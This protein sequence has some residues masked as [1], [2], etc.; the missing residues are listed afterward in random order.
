M[1]PTHVNIDTIILYIARTWVA[2]KTNA[3]GSAQYGQ[4]SSRY[5]ID[6][7][8]VGL[9]MGSMKYDNLSFAIPRDIHLVESSE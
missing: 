1:K 4:S 9:S 8:S 5:D 2:N 3:R 7:Y 6:F